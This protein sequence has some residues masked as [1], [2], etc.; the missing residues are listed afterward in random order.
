MNIRGT[1]GLS[2]ADVQAEI[3]RGARFVAYQYCVSLAVVTLKR[4]SSIHYLKPGQNGFVPGFLWSFF[5]LIVGWWGIPWGPIYT[6]GALWTNL[7]GGIDVTASVAA[8]LA[9]AGAPPPLPG[10]LA[11]GPRWAAGPLAALGVFAAAIFAAVAGVQYHAQQHRP[12]AL[13]NGLATAYVAEIDGVRHELAPRSTKKLELPEGVH[14]VVATLPGGLGETRFTFTAG[15]ATVVNPD[16]AALVAEETCIYTP[17]DQPTVDSPD[18]RLHSGRTSYALNR[19]DYFLEEFPD[20]IDMPKHASQTERDRI[21]VLAKFNYERAAGIVL[22]YSGRPALVAYFKALGERL[23]NDQELIGAALETLNPA[24]AKAFFAAHLATR[25]ALVEWHRGYQNFVL[26]Q[27]PDTD[28]A[29]EYRRLAETEPEEGAFAYLYGRL[30]DNP[31]EDTAWFERALA[32]KRPC[33]YGHFALAYSA[34][35]RG[36]YADALAALGQART[37]G[38][39]NDSVREQ[40][41]DCL[42]ALRRFDEA[43]KEFE[44]QPAAA[45]A[46]FSRANDELHLRYLAGGKAA[47]TRVIDTFLAHLP[48]SVRKKSGA[49]VRKDF[50]A[51]LA[52]FEGNIARYA[53]SISPEAE[54]FTLAVRAIC[55]N[56]NAAAEEALAELPTQNSTSWFLLYLSARLAGDGE[57]ETYWDNAVAALAHEPNGHRRLA[58][59]FAGTTP[60]S[61]AELVD[62]PMAAGEKRLFLAALGLHEPALRTACFARAAQCN[63]NR[64]FPHHLVAAALATARP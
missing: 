33:A 12:V 6:I 42:L 60:L 41:I 30:L 38:L 59:H 2:P 17:K 49:E 10:N 37:T 4:V 57:A 47:A 35:A 55:Q 28:L 18:P 63:F 32:A 40:R 15:A 53:D 13:A 58:A 23:P 43:L 11:A 26:H 45:V 1:E 52:Y 9:G 36:N 16:A 31:A 39:D 20:S 46:D 19:P 21:A 7:R 24:E 62:F 22:R 56:D 27:L 34:A 50:E 5:S 29:A 64:R 51:Q 25:P 54:G 3:A 48:D 8:D 14:T 44:G 61:T